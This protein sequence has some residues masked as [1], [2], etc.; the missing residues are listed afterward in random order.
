MT[1]NLLAAWMEKG[2]VVFEAISDWTGFVVRER[3][4][5]IV[6]AVADG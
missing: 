5:I 1:V 4:F 2:L 3:R 6:E